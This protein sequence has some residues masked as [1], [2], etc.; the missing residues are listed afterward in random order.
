MKTKKWLSLSLLL[1]L[2]ACSANPHLKTERARNNSQSS[3]NAGTTTGSSGGTTCGSGVAG[4]GLSC[5]GTTSDGNG[6]GQYPIANYQI[7]LAGQQDWFPQKTTDLI[8]PQQA[9]TQMRFTS[10]GRLRA[11]IKVNPQASSYLGIDS[12]GQQIP[13]CPGRIPG[14]DAYGAFRY[15]KLSMNIEFWATLFQGGK[16]VPSQL[17]GSTALTGISVGTCS[18]VIDLPAEKIKLTP[19]PIIV[20][21]S[22]VSTDMF[23]A[24]TG[25]NCPSERIMRPQDCYDIVLQVV[26]DQSDDFK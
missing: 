3:L 10:D 19:N 20:K 23:C 18:Q 13:G 14:S 17:L 15:S 22:Q 5:S 24:Q 6:C 1:T 11:R 2:L 8:Y 9:E 25:T 16:Y 12:S 21:V 4:T 7:V 26:N